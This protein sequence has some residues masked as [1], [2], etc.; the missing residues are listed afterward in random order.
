MANEVKELAKETAKAT[1]DIASKIEVIQGDSKAAIEAMS[2]IDQIMD[3]INQAQSTIASAVE[4]QTATTNEIGRTV[5]EVATGSGDI[6][7]NIG[8]VATRRRTPPTGPPRPNGPRQRW[9]GWRL[10]WKDC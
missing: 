7:Q 3:K 2:Q 1:G 9:G 6:A 10:S 4:E 5:A 8:H